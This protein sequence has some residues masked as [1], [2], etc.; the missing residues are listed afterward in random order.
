MW[1]VLTQGVPDAVTR[2]AAPQARGEAGLSNAKQRPGSPMR[3][4]LARQPFEE[5]IRKVGQLVKLSA[6]V[7]SARVREEVQMTPHTFRTRADIAE[8]SVKR[9]FGSILESVEGAGLTQLLPE[10]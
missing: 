3:R 7:K 1:G 2:N 9:Q 5:K 4:S 8:T 6:S 10:K